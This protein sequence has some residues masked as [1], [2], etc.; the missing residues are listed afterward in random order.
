MKEKGEVAGG[1]PVIV[2]AVT[3]P[4]RVFIKLAVT[5]FS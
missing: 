5:Q 4:L 3:K 2:I 1:A